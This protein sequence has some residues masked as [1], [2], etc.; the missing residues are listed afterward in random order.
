MALPSRRALLSFGPVPRHAGC[1]PCPWLRHQP[2]AR[3]PRPMRSRLCY[4]FR[5]GARRR[6]SGGGSLAGC[7]RTLSRNMSLSVVGRWCFLRRSRKASSAS[8]CTD[9]MLSRESCF[10]ACQVSASNSIRRRTE[11]GGRAAISPWPCAFE[12]SRSAPLP[13]CQA[14]VSPCACRLDRLQRCAA[15]HPS[16]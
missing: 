7:M 1:V 10:R 14:L 9:F 8:S 5:F 16:N 2:P 15:R 13:A 12:A 11:P 3:A 4:D 6:G